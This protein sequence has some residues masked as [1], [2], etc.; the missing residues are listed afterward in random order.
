MSAHID[1]MRTLDQQYL[2]THPEG[3]EKANFTLTSLIPEHLVPLNPDGSRQKVSVKV[4]ADTY[5]AGLTL[6][7]A[8]REDP[9]RILSAWL[10]EVLPPKELKKAAK[11]MKRGVRS[12]TA[13][14]AVEEIHEKYLAFETG[15]SFELTV[16]GKATKQAAELTITAPSVIIGVQGFVSATKPSSLQN[17]AIAFCPTVEDEY[18]EDSENTV[19][20]R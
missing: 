2:A 6:L 1:V 12:E 15:A 7:D 13:Q 11:L 18:D 3:D 19:L 10:Q 4:L 14:A 16:S 8:L 20:V 5:L 17:A 9:E